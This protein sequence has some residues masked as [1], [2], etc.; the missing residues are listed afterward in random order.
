MTHTYVKYYYN[1][2]IYPMTDFINR[3]FQSRQTWRENS[4]KVRLLKSK[5]ASR[6]EIGAKTAIYN[7]GLTYRQINP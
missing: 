2:Y 4:W 6:G 3:S 1:A 7:N 5:S